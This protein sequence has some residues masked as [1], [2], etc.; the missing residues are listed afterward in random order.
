MTDRPIVEQPVEI[1]MGTFVV[2]GFLWICACSAESDACSTVL[3]AEQAARA[4]AG[5]HRHD[6]HLLYHCHRCNSRLP[7][8]LAAA[9]EQGC[10]LGAAMREALAAFGGPR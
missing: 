7:P 10:A 9:H 5:A 6:V 1:T 4:M 8:A 3:D 2:G